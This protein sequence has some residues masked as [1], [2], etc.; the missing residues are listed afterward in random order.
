MRLLIASLA[1]VAAIGCGSTTVHRPQQ[2]TDVARRPPGDRALARAGL[3]RVS[4]LPSGWGPSASPVRPRCVH[5]TRLAGVT[6]AARTPEFEL[7]FRHVRSTTAVF[8]TPADATRAYASL[9]SPR[10]TRCFRRD[11]RLNLSAIGRLAQ[12][13]TVIRADGDSGSRRFERRIVAQVDSF[14]SIF[15]IYFD[16][17]LVRVDRG[18]SSLLIVSGRAPAAED[19]Y[20]SL[21][22]A[23]TRR[24]SDAMRPAA[25]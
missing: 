20:L 23:S 7:N 12:P 2:R 1:S 5:T 24:L 14:G 21:V 19:F 18:L 16:S 4:D 8:R 25:R 13:P 9:T 3:L 10:T 15:P 17:V 6:G 11:V 22:H